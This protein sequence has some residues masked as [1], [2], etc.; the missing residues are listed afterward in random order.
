MMH[1]ARRPPRHPPPM[2][3]GGGERA[4][5]MEK[6]AKGSGEWC[7]GRRRRAGYAEG[8]VDAAVFLARRV[9]AADAR[10]SYTM[11]DVLRA[12]AMD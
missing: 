1:W 4:M 6:G 9:A 5:Q 2:R 12:G 8:T 7:A 3:I 11:I 10:T